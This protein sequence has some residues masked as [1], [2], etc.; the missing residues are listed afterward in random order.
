MH[1][2]PNAYTYAIDAISVNQGNLRKRRN[3]RMVS[4]LPF[5]NV[6]PAVPKSPLALCR[7]VALK[8]PAEP[9]PSGQCFFV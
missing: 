6:V 7:H 2:K 3:P 4:I 9:A 8:G 1:K 5:A